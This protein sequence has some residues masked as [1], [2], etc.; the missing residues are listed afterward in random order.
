MAANMSTNHGTHT[1]PKA[2]SNG[3][4]KGADTLQPNTVWSSKAT[5]LTHTTVWHRCV[6]PTPFKC[7]KATTKHTNSATKAQGVMGGVVAHQGW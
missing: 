6:V 1:A 5:L 2:W 7:T 3:C 4:H